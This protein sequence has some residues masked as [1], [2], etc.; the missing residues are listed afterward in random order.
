MRI[1]P[2]IIAFI[3]AT[4]SKLLPNTEVYIFG[5]RVDDNERGGD[6]D[7]LILSDQK[8]DRKILRSFRIEFFKKF[9]WQKL[10]LINFTKDETS[11]FKQLI[12]PN[13]QL[14]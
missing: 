11:T 7:V 9:G 8:I 5:S 2:E 6:I 14:I 12:L 13:A 1:K 10:D 4:A 3:K